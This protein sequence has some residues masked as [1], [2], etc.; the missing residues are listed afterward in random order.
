MREKIIQL[1]TENNNSERGILTIEY[2]EEYVEKLIKNAVII[3]HYEEGSLQGF[4]AFYANDPNKE[5]AFLSLILVSPKMQG[6]K[7]GNF[8]IQYSVAVLQNRKFQFYDLEVLK[9]NEK[10]L[11]FYKK[12]GFEVIGEKDLFYIMRKKL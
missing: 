12:N 10:A 3:P 6:Q 11:F 9:I 8:L 2:V 4:I 5:K 7:I 1:I